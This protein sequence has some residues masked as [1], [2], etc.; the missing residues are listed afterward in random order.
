ME[1]KTTEPVATPAGN[2][3]TATPPQPAV[4][5][6]ALPAPAVPAA[7]TPAMPVAASL[8]QI[9]AAC[10]GADDA[11]VMAQLK[12]KVSVEDARTN[13]ATAQSAKITELE[14]QSKANASAN[15]GVPAVT[16]TQTGEPKGAAGGDPI[17]AFDDAVAE[18]V[19][20]GMNKRAAISDVVA[21][22]PE[23]HQAYV[24]AYNSAHGRKVG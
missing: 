14:A 24:A 19:K 7:V 5:T 12:G 18:K 11:F 21:Q 1:T 15:V 2:A 10:V 3:A 13:W 16:G 8:E 6:D 17:A 9:Q 22:N 23:M 20:A 4:N